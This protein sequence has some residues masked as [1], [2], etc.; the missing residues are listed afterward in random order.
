MIIKRKILGNLAPG[1]T[2]CVI[3]MQID[4]F[5][6]HAPPQAFR[7]DIVQGP[8]FPIHANAHRLVQE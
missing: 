6:F 8:T 1:L 4:F 5:I 3:V 2:G 7:K